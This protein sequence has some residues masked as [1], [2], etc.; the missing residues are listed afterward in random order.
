MKRRRRSLRLFA[1]TELRARVC[2]SAF[3]PKGESFPKILGKISR[4]EAARNDTRGKVL[5][6]LDASS[7]LSLRA[8]A[9]SEAI[10]C[11]AVREMA[12]GALRPRHDANHYQPKLGL[13]HVHFFHSDRLTQKNSHD[14]L[15]AAQ[16]FVREKFFAGV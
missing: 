13:L 3:R 14:T 2:L 11:M 7:N 12:S 5:L 10:P 8:T 9:G 6:G 16:L 4:R 1:F 15:A